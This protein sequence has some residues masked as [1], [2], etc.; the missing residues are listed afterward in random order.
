MSNINTTKLSYKSV[1]WVFGTTSLRPAQLSLKI[2]K[3]LQLL[4][5]LRERRKKWSKMDVAGQ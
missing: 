5:S 4:R 2:E 1:A 3:Q